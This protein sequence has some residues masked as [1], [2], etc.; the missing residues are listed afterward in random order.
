MKNV[1]LEDVDEIDLLHVFVDVVAF[2]LSNSFFPVALFL[3]NLFTN[4]FAMF[5]SSPRS[6]LIE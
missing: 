4:F 5:R 2:G 3:I 6:Q 1:V